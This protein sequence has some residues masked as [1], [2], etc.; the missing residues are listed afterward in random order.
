MNDWSWLWKIAYSEEIRECNTESYQRSN[1][2]L[3][4]NKFKSSFMILD[5]W[6]LD[7]FLVQVTRA[8]DIYFCI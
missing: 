3:L 6:K 5:F 8:I 1:N 7:S 4:S 2:S